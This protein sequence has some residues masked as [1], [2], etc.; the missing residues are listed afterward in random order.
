LPGAHIGL[1]LLF[2]DP[3]ATGGMETYARALVPLLPAAVPDARFT[4]WPGAS[5]RVEPDQ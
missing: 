5:L 4:G 3:G 1:D 2:L